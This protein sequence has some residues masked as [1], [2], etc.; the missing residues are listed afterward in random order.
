MQTDGFS[1]EAF[2]ANSESLWNIFSSALGESYLLFKM[3]KMFF[4]KQGCEQ[5]KSCKSVEHQMK[6]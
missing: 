5:L 3:E 2:K 1:P 4:G 6:H